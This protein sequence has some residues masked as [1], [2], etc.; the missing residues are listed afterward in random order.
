MRTDWLPPD[1][2]VTRGLTAPA[3]LIAKQKTPSCFAC[4]ARRS[5]PSM[6]VTSGPGVPTGNPYLTRQRPRAPSSADERFDLPLTAKVEGDLSRSVSRMCRP[7][8]QSKFGQAIFGRL[9]FFQSARQDAETPRT[10]RR[11]KGDIGDEQG[12]WGDE[13]WASVAPLGRRVF[14]RA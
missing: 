6:R 10:Q 13:G 2:D 8:F 3:R 1:C 14:R 12:M 4:L 7:T 11:R 5:V 9:R